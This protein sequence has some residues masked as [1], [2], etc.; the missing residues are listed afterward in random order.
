MEAFF[1]TSLSDVRV[2]VGPQ[3]SSIGAIAFCMGTDLFFAPGR[4][5]VRTPHGRQLLGHE[6]AHV[7][8]QRSGRVRNPFDSGVA[9]VQDPRL[10]V[11]AEHLGE[12][13]AREMTAA[14]QRPSSPA[15][16]NAV[17]RSTA[18][19]G[20]ALWPPGARTVVQ[21]LRLAGPSPSWQETAS[22]VKRKPSKFGTIT[23]LDFGRGLE[24]A[25]CCPG[26]RRWLPLTTATVDH[27][28]PKSIVKNLVETEGP[29]KV[30]K[31]TKKYKADYGLE[32]PLNFTKIRYWDARGR[33]WA[34][35]KLRG[36][37]LEEFVAEHSGNDLDNLRLMC[38]SCNS[39]KRDRDNPQGSDAPQIPTGAPM[40]QTIKDNNGRK[41][42]I[43]LAPD[44][45][46]EDSDPTRAAFTKAWQA[47]RQYFLAKKYY[48]PLT[49]RDFGRGAEPAYGCPDCGRSLPIA[50]ATVD[51][52][53]AKSL[54]W[55]RSLDLDNLQLMC[56][57][58]NC[59][60]GNR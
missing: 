2:Y 9:V 51:H 14:L 39:S 53:L 45:D 47:T 7:V 3:A 49:R 41:I 59:S 43:K 18:F 27:I 40:T 29:G 28:V 4:F 55:W 54:A 38:H 60:K 34:T 6:L 12:M 35:K 19:T 44:V 21:P 16:S 17:Q 24:R 15:P 58:C 46:K 26:C 13:A 8:Q 52:I 33:S 1:K 36:W 11:E 48:T 32:K 50:I 25:F 42:A 37:E 57:I 56:N 23:D 30:K 5:D 20:P 10:E 22:Y 31:W